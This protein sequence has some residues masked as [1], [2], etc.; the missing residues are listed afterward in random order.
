MKRKY[1]L[2]D[3]FCGAGGM[4]L[5]FVDKRYCGSFQS[6]FAIDNDLAA[7]QTY[8]SNFGRNNHCI[9]ANIEDWLGCTEVP[10]ADLV[11]GGPPCQGFSSAGRRK[12]DDPRLHR[13]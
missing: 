1:K 8:N 5:G 2:I 7:T 11:I 10:Q 12:H 3:L 9:Q 4:T 13:A 6:I